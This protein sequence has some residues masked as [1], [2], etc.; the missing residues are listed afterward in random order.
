MIKIKYRVETEWKEST[1]IEVNDEEL[2]FLMT[3]NDLW[4]FTS[5]KTERKHPH[6]KTYEYDENGNIT[7]VTAKV[8]ERK[9]WGETVGYD[10]ENISEALTKFYDDTGRCL[11]GNL[12]IRIL[13]IWR[14]DK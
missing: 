7:K 5:R 4:D 12:K 14:E 10:T 11:K 6:T 8:M 13:D 1:Y 3:R 9:Y 2:E